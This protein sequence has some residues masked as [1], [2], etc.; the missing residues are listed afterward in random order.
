MNQKFEF[1]EAG[2]PGLIEI[3]PFNVDDVRGCFTK[4]Y[5]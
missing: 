2:I 5:S 3:T 1:T 4:D